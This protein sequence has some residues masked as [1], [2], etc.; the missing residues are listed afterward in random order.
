[1]FDA[2]LTCEN[3]GKEIDNVLNTICE[4]C[5]KDNEED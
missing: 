1:M 5:A 4:D 3:C 2:P